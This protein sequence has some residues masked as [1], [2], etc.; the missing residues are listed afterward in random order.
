LET[1]ILAENQAPIGVFI[2]TISTTLGDPNI[3]DGTLQVT[4]GQTITV[5][6]Y[7]ANDGTGNPATVT[8]TAVADC[9]GP[10]ISNVEVVDLKSLEVTIRFET[11]EP[12]TAQIRC[13]LACSGPYTIASNDLV[14]ATI[15]SIQLTGLS[16]E[17]TYYFVID[18]TDAANNQS[19]ADNGGYA[20]SSP[21]KQFGTYMYRVS[22]LR[23]SPQLTQ[24]GM[25]IPFRWMIAYTQGQ[26]I[27][28]STLRAR[29]SL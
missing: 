1:V 20:L 15:H 5:T 28:I 14:L 8:D 19:T 24:R 13:G 17:T 3:E 10:A 18:A 22:I 26:G 29:P 11:D 23:F 16:S 9:E 21:R 7:D 27:A 12:T 2:G 25:E 4:H 6:Y